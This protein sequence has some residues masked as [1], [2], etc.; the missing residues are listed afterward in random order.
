MEALGVWDNYAPTTVD[1]KVSIN[2]TASNYSLEYRLVYIIHYL[3]NSV[4]APIFVQIS[5]KKGEKL[6]S[7]GR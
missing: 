2:V 4:T 1:T 7:E 3:G 6:I 5:S